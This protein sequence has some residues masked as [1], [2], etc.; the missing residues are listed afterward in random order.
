MRQ[1]TGT[2]RDG[3]GERDGTRQ[4]GDAGPR[5]G[6]DAD[7]DGGT[8]GTAPYAGNAPVRQAAP[9]VLDLREA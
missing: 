7:A 9:R 6:T 4:D 2:E 3:A 5:G 8:G 1:Q